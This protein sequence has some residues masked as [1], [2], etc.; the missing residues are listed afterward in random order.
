VRLDNTAP[1]IPVGS[2]FVLLQQM[3]VLND[4]LQPVPTNIAESVQLR[5]YA[6]IDGSSQPPMNTGVG[7]NV[8]DYRL[9]RRLLFDG[10]QHGGLEREPEDEGAYR[11]AI[12]GS[13][14]TAPDWGFA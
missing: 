14:Q 8:L 11:V 9:K 1:P 3:V 6:N 2:E 13:K 10:L 7:M 12:D 4:Q 5:V